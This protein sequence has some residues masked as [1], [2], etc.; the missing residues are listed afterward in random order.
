[1]IEA[2]SKTILAWKFSGPH[3]H[4]TKF[5]P[6][7]VAAVR[8]PI[9]ELYAD[10]GYLSKVNCAAAR[11]AGATPFIR[12]KKTTRIA[13]PKPDG[14]DTRTPFQ[15]MVNSEQTDRT[16]WYT[17][18]G[19]RNRVEST[20]GAIKRRFGGRLRAMNQ[21]TRVV[22]AALKVLVWNLTRVRLGEF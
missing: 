3:E 13:P 14:P 15:C 4:D 22:E 21:A 17:R 11:K 5:F 19:R 9:R 20:F 12:P 7:L 8:A 6:E 1:M 16:A 10:A 2:E 18:Y